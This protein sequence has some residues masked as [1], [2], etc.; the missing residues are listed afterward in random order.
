M[1]L[2][3]RISPSESESKNLARYPGFRM[4]ELISRVSRS[5]VNVV[6]RCLEKVVGN[7]IVCVSYSNFVFFFFY[8]FTFTL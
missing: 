3:A 2:S 1:H 7:L 4:I 8:L 6:R 5:T